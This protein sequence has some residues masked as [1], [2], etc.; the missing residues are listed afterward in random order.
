MSAEGFYHDT[1]PRQHTDVL[2]VHIWMHMYTCTRAHTAYTLMIIRMRTQVAL[3]HSIGVVMPSVHNPVAKSCL[4]SS[5]LW[6]SFSPS[7][8]HPKGLCPAEV[9]HSLSL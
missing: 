7:P 8:H 9:Q 2:H 6:S 4:A 3:L 1:A 5:S